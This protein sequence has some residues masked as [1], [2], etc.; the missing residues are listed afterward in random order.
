MENTLFRTTPCPDCGVEMLW[1]QNAWKVGEAGQAAY[2]C[3]NGH[4][5]DPAVTRQCP[6][7]GIHDTTL[8]SERD[9]QQE[10]RCARCS[11]VFAF[12]R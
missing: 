8:V 9:G 6:S 11:A 2:R 5:L 12:P 7:C 10:F 4:V 1:T 3:D